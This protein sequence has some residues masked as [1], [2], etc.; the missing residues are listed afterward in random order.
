MRTHK[1]ALRSAFA[2]L[3]FAFLISLCIGK[4][5]L[6]LAGIISGEG[7]SRSVFLILRLSR[8]LMALLAGFGLAFAGYAY[9]SIL[10]NPIASPEVIGVSS[11]ACVGAAVSIVYCGGA[12]ITTAVLSFFGGMCAVLLCFALAGFARN[13]KI[14]S[15]VVAGIAINSLSQAILML[16]KTAADPLN[17]LASIEFWTMGS[18]SAITASKIL[19]VVPVIL[20]GVVLLFKLHRQIALLSLEA[21]SAQMLGATVV[22]LRFCLLIIATAVVSSVVCV[23]GLISFVG[24]IAPHL[25]RL[26]FRNQHQNTLLFSGLIGGI[27]MIFADCVARSIGT[28]ELPISVVTSIIGFP[29]LVAL[30]LRGEKIS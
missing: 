16:I 30:V 9:Q 22:R 1:L 29:F 12:V 13:V 28:N 10:K 8:T 11:G 5:P 17:Q 26:I 23:C 4:Y 2:L 3:V 15:I 20:L 19:P 27:L 18:L 25:A 24:L 21:D 6:T 7:S 14:A